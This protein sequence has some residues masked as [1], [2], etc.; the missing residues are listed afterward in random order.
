VL[1]YL[2]F[3]E[4]RPDLGIGLIL[5]IVAGVAI[6]IAGLLVPGSRPRS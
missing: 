5:T 2:D 1:L 4:P 3:P 6:A